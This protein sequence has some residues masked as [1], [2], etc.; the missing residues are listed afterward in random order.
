M[1]RRVETRN[2]LPVT[3]FNEPR[4]VLLV[5]GETSADRYGAALVRKLRAVCAHRP[6]TFFGTGGDEMQNEGV[7]L[8][9]H[10]RELHGIGVRDA[11]Q[12]LKAYLRVFRALTE[13]CRQ[14]RPAAAVLLDFP[15]FNLRLAKRLKRLG[16]KVIYYIS[17]QLWAWRG[18]RIKIVRKYVDHMLVILP[19]E[20][21]FYR[22]RGIKVA[23]VGHPLLE[24]FAVNS[25][26]ESFARDL[27]LDPA[28]ATVA[29]LP[30]SRRGEVEYILPTFLEASRL[31]LRRMPAQF[32]I[33]LAPAI[34]PRQVS[35]IC[36]Q[37]LG[38]NGGRRWFRTAPIPA[39][40]ILANSDFGFIKCGT[41]TLEAALVGTPFLISYRVA[42][43]NWLINKTMI[44]S[45]FKGLVNLIAG[46]EIVPEYLQS[47]ATPET[48]SR[49][50][51][52]FLQKPEKA[53]A[54]KA[55]LATVRDMLGTHRAS[56]YAA[57][58]LAGYLE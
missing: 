4:T 45:P 8:L 9:C 32:V 29:L 35:D 16:I 50:A 34:D 14:R 17:P 20:E 22:T 19:F 10:I 25:D 42:P 30:G 40:T 52:E 15:E 28:R 21:E 57:S 46:E 7:E 24:D 5:V 49:V 27:G 1:N 39:R 38:D 33:S 31:I 6:L 44:R 48:L 58:L 54:M 18:G 56:D 11:F 26:R 13:A 53:A 12:N 47:E 36:A 37:V 55:R 43:V 3:D 2:G 41:S 51:L 23:F